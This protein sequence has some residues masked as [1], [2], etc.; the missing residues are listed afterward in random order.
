MPPTKFL[1]LPFELRQ[2]VYGYLDTTAGPTLWFRCWGQRLGCQNPP[3]RTMFFV[4]KQVIADMI[5]LTYLRGKFTLRITT[6]TIPLF[7]STVTLLSTNN[8]L[9][10]SHLTN[11][12]FLKDLFITIV[13]NPILATDDGQSLRRT[14]RPLLSRATNLRTVSLGISSSHLQAKRLHGSGRR[15]TFARCLKL[16]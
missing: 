13:D 4:C 2:Q 1:D 16:S 8:T 11:L 10:Q 6:S 7:P 14:I 9:L 15:I 12:A 5:G 3:P